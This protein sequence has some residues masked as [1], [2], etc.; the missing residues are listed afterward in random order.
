MD[1]NYSK[2]WLQKSQNEGAIKR[3]RMAI[4]N[5]GR[6]LPCRVVAVD[7]SIVT[8]AFEVD[9]APQTLPQITIPKAESNWMRMPTQVGDFGVTMP[10]DAYLGGVSGLGGG[11]ANLARR[12]NLSAL[13][14]VP[15]SSK[16]APPDNVNAAQVM[17]P[18]GVILRT[19]DNSC[20]LVLN[21]DGLTITFG[22][23]K[24]VIDS[25]GHHFTGAVTGD[26]TAEFDGEGTFNGGHTVSAHHH[27]VTGVQPGSATINSQ[28]PTG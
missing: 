19:A 14:F 20:S 7:G 16:A 15:I 10:A 11:T 5:E 6:A 1:G 3:A 24:F 12:G 23:V 9:A 18:E 22:G 27:P 2:L 4:E 21:G 8:V 25:S 28:P 17:G 13:V 26:S